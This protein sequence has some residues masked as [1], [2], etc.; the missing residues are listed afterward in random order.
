MQEGGDPVGACVLLG[1]DLVFVAAAHGQQAVDVGLAQVFARVLGA[2]VRKDVHELFL[3][4]EE[5]LLLRK[6]DGRCREGLGEG[7]HAVLVLRA[8]GRPP[9]FRADLAM[10]QDHQAVH[11]DARLPSRRRN[12]KMALEEMPTDSGETRSNRSGNSP[13][14]QRVPLWGTKN[15][16]GA[17]P[18]SS[19][20]RRFFSTPPAYPVRLPFA[21]HHAVAGDQERD[22][23]AP[24]GATDGLRRHPGAGRS[25]AR[26]ARRSPHRSSSSHRE[27][28]AGF[29]KPFS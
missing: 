26:S 10:A 8:I 4:R 17:T 6:P 1:G 15:V 7:K 21:S 20:R 24:N 16:S 29:P 18:S 23:I 14:L 2:Q 5:A 27:W 13:S 19:R 22:R 3:Q 11:L 28:P 9:P 12:S 25:A